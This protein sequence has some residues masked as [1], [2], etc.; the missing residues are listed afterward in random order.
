MVHVTTASKLA[1]ALRDVPDLL[2]DGDDS[3]TRDRALA[4]LDA[5]DSLEFESRSVVVIGGGGSGKSSVVNALVGT[6]VAEVSP[7]RPTTTGVLVVGRSDVSSMEGVVEYTFTDLVRE[8]VV[9]VDTPSWDYDRDTVLAS[10]AG[11][12]T[13]VVV[14]TPSRYGD[15]IT[16]EMVGGLP[17][18]ARTVIIANRMP[19][20]AEQNDD[21][22]DGIEATFELAIYAQVFEGETLSLPGSIIGDMPVDVGA[23]KSKKAYEIETSDA[24]RVIAR[25]VSASAVELG[26]VERVLAD[27][28]TPS[29]LPGVV[30]AGGEWDSVR[31][32]LV[33]AV[34]AS[35]RSL[36]ETIIERSKNELAARISGS[37]GVSDL[38][39]VSAVLD[40]WRSEVVDTFRRR[41][42]VRWRR[43]ATLEMLDTWSWIMSIDPHSRPPR[44]VRR[45]V[46]DIRE[47][48]ARESEERLVSILDDAVRDRRD[49]W[50]SVVA[51]IG[52]Y[53]PGLLFAA[54]DA[55][56]GGEAPDE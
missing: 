30:W 29:S 26:V 47:A 39:A 7:I 45:A 1:S 41:A 24:G 33:D 12:H 9:V 14:V 25:S 35:I 3:E 28:P 4:S 5:L 50:S 21:V 43:E 48:T 54:S 19:R 18:T 23:L 52:Q 17:H 31:T 40:G 44:R 38:T 15:A 16:S 49:Q 8:G 20:D 42:T 11:A 2:M 13:V 55:L 6:G 51:V 37:L 46:R 32:S 27:T 56:D 22:L 53:R 36:D 10:V 34:G